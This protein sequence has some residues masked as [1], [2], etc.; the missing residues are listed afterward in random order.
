MDKKILG[1]ALWYANVYQYL[2]DRTPKEL[3]SGYTQWS[4]HRR[5]YAALYD[6]VNLTQL[7]AAQGGSS[8]TLPDRGMLFTFHYGP[9]R[10][11]PR[12]LVAHGLRIALLAS[13]AIVEREQAQ[14]RKELMQAQLPPD[15]LTCIPADDPMVLRRILTAIRD[16]GRLV[17]VF[18]DANEGLVSNQDTRAS[19]LEIP[20]GASHF[21]WRT[22]LL[23]LADRF[24]LPIATV[25]LQEDESKGD[26]HIHASYA[27]DPATEGDRS[28]F[29]AR[30]YQ[31]LILTFQR[32][33]ARD[34]TAWENWSLLHAYGKER[35][36]RALRQGVANWMIPLTVH[37]KPYL[38]DVANSR[39]FAIETG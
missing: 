30:A 17:L 2:S 29:V 35:P 1:K 4:A 9:Y 7:I 12:L 34:W 31:M 10:L 13:A 19:G 3:E 15:Q 28:F 8:L 6:H 22:N 27:L 36:A 18:V 39:F 11:L 21:R 38:F 24:D 20:F 37:S 23:R 14:Y 33:M 25:Y 5:A 26:W 16:E 32:I